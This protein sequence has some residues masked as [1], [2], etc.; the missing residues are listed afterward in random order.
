MP[1]D[2]GISGTLRKPQTFHKFTYLAGGRSLVSLP[3][4]AVMIGT[5]KGGT[6][7]AGTIYSIEA[8]ETSDALFGVGTELAIMLRKCFETGALLGQGPAL[9]AVGVAEP[10]GGSARVQTLTVTGPATASGNVV[11]RIAGRTITTGVTTGDVANT[12]AAAIQKEISR[13]N[14]VLPVTAA[15]ATNVV[16]CTTNYKG[17]NG[18]DVVFEV[19][20]QPAGITVASVQSV[21]GSGVADYLTALANVL[22]VD[23]DGIAFGNHA[24]ADVVAALAHIASAWAPSEKKWR[25]IGLGESG[26][27]G[28]A[29]AL[30]AAANDKA[31]QVFACEG[32]P[33]LP[34]ELAAAGIVGLLSR[35]RPNANYDGM[36]LPIYPPADS[37]VFTNTEIETALAAGLTPLTSIVDPFSRVT[38]QGVAQ[39]VRM[40]TTMTTQGGLP[41][42]PLRD[43]AVARTGAFIARQID[44]GFQ[45]RFG[46]AAA[47][48]GVLLTD[49]T[50]QQVR[51]MVANILYA[52]QAV[53]ILT[54]V[55]NDIKLLVV[56]KDLSAPGRI[57]VDVTYTVV[58]GLHQVAF[59]HR[60]QI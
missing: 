12:V 39:I 41:F 48:D 25:W 45:N 55:D 30:A 31:I 5:Q 54:N 14:A 3:Q 7:T 11:I 33:S 38:K 57:N 16:T 1:I 20:S 40:V 56:E 24:A 10:G 29:T 50:I 35:T 43:V 28:T 17:V 53:S 4:R 32:T 58:L 15:V 19:V 51:D 42:E 6:A 27:I 44:V 9:F 46:A 18:L 37:L 26:S 60:V 21:A 22:G 23:Y 52:A 2:T 47:P 59:V 34:S 13:Y 8:P 36:V 49:D